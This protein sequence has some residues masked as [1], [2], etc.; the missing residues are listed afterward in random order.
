MVV[1]VIIC[2]G[3]GFPE[4]NFYL[5]ERANSFLGAMDEAGSSWARAY[6]EYKK[7][8]GKP[9]FSRFSRSGASVNPTN[10]FG[11]RTSNP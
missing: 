5:L 7:I 9:H 1:C 10:A 2:F 6:S 3:L 11:M 4:D 8:L